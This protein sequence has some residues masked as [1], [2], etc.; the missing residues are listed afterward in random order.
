MKDSSTIVF[1][2]TERCRVHRP[3]GFT[4][5]RNKK[6]GGWAFALFFFAVGRMHREL[7]LWW[8]I[9]SLIAGNGRRVSTFGMKFVSAQH[10]LSEKI[11]AEIQSIPNGKEKRRRG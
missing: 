11:Y 10:Q 8:K 9:G 5:W 1:T 7:P 3:T 4:Y 6:D 2:T